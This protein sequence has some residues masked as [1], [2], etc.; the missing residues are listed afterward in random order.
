MTE[1]LKGDI[2]TKLLSF[3]KNQREPLKKEQLI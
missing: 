2:E 1:M 3:L